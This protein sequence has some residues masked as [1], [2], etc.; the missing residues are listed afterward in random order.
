MNIVGVKFS[1][2]GR[3]SYCDPAGLLLAVG[4]RVVVEAAEGPREGEV[5]I[6]PDQVLFSNLV[7]PMD[8]VLRKVERR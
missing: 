1:P 6:A 7:G 8:P 3:V 2:W 5:V 4:D